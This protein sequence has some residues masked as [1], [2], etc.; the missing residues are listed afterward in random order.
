[1]LHRSGIERTVSVQE[2]KKAGTI[3]KLKNLPRFTFSEKSKQALG[4]LLIR[5]P[6]GDED[7]GEIVG[8][9]S[10]STDRTEQKEDDFFGRPDM[11]KADITKQLE[12]LNARMNTSNLKLV[13][14][15]PHI[16][17]S[18]TFYMIFVGRIL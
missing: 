12:D 16:Y 6:P 5:Y 7:S 9:N 10:Y 1:M 18:V 15:L 8:T 14:F 3:T 2:I 13:H 4:G 17:I 11:N